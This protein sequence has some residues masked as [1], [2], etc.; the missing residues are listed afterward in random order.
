M[1]ALGA[2][3]AEARDTF[4]RGREIFEEIRKTGVGDGRFNLLSM[5]MTSDF[6]AAIAEGS[7]LVRIGAAIFGE[8][9][10]GTVEEAEEE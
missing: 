7:N 8:P 6:E 9:K 3:E 1:A 10:P 4:A 2:S 5:G